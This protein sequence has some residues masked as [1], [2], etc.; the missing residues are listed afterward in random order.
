MDSQIKTP[1]FDNFLNEILENLKPHQRACQQCGKLFNIFQEDIEFYRI[2]RVPPPKLCSACRR[3]RRMG[4]YNNILKFYKKECLTHPEEKKSRVELY[5]GARIVS[6]FPPESPYKIYDLKYW[7]SDKWG[8]EDYAMDY[9]FSKPFFEQF[10][11]LNF[12]APHPAITQYWKNVI[13]SPYTISI[14]D[15]KNCYLTASGANLENVF[16]SYWVGY[17][18]DCLELLDTGHCENCYELINSSGC[19]NSHFCEDCGS[20]VDSFFLYSCYH[21]ENCFACVNLRNKQY[22]FF[23][24]QFSKQEYQKKIK[25]INLGDRDILEEY[26]EKFE[27]LLKKSARRN[28]TTYEANVNCLGDRLWQAKNCYLVF[29][30]GSDIENVRYGVDVCLGVKDSMD[31]W[32]VGPNVSLSYETI[33]ILESS[34]VKFSFFIRN[35]LDLEYCLN[36]FNC[37]NCFACVSLR[38]KSY[39]IF[40]KQYSKQEYFKILDEI[41]TKMLKNGEYGEFFPLSMSLYPYNNTYA[42]IEFPLS[43]EEVIKNNWQWQNEEK[44]LIDFKKS[45]FIEAKDLPKD[46]KDV[47]DDI[48]NKTIICE[49]TGKLFR[50]VKP[51]LKFYRK[52]NLPLPT[53]HP[54]QRIFERL[55]TRNPL[56]LWKVIC[57][58]CLKKMYTS[59]PPEKQ[60]QLKIYCEA[61]YIREVV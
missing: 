4:F 45:E 41:K 47:G 15:S 26:R 11:K 21:C 49:D 31:L 1:N 10:Q 42:M 37:E 29:R 33:E 43:K 13:D 17:C 36:C 23:N 61:C 51:E 38:N 6:T 12:S 35:G 55:Q 24:E 22:C 19:Y 18:K 9:D 20:C 59:Y 39:C 56:K 34:N 28:L 3:Q 46:I 48:L 27:L 14:I 57:P 44:T 40:N 52:H 54:C 25:D 50:I 7:W 8:G 32:V 60:K 2:L 53:M 58:K 5:S 30:S 16:F